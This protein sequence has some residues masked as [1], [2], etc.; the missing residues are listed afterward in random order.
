EDKRTRTDSKGRTQTY[1]VT[2]FKG[3]L[4]VADFH[5][6]FKSEVTVMPD[7]AESAFGRI[8]RFFQKLGGDL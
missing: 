2:I 6:H 3:L 4:V 1:W 5:K 8:G 7:F